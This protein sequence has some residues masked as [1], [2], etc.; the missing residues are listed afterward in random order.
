MAPVGLDI[1]DEVTAR[2]AREIGQRITGGVD[3]HGG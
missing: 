2:V 1:P 3:L